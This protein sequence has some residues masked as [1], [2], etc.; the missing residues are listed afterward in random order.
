MLV[1]MLIR[2]RWPEASGCELPDVA[3]LRAREKK[4]GKEEMD[5][6]VRCGQV[7]IDDSCTP[8]ETEPKGRI[9]QGHFPWTRQVTNLT[10]NQ[11]HGGLHW[12]LRGT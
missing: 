6:T 3:R 11:W 12:N 4:A 8:R 5:R 2:H 7:Q 1:A 9:A 10:Q